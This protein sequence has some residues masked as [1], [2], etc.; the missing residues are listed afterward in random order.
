MHGDRSPEAEKVLFIMGLNNSL[1]GWEHQVTHFASKPGY[2]VVCFDNRG[3]GNSD[4]P[5]GRYKASP[6][7]PEGSGA[8]APSHAGADRGVW[9]GLAADERDG[10][11][12]GRPVGSPRVD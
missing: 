9:L 10:A 7:P 2:Q 4:S 1:W 11:R 6:R 12:R 3:V 8:V 5:P